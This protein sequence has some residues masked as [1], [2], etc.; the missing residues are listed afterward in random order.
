MSNLDELRRMPYQDRSPAFL[1]SSDDVLNGYAPFDRTKFLSEGRIVI[2]GL[3]RSGNHWLTNLIADSLHLTFAENVTFTHMPLT[4]SQTEDKTLIRAV[5]L[6]RDIRDVIVSLYHFMHY[7]PVWQRAPLIHYYN[8]EQYY[9]DIFVRCY[10]YWPQF[11]EA[12]TQHILSASLGTMPVVHYERLWDDTE[13]E[14]KWLFDWWNIDVSEDNIKNSIETNTIETYRNKHKE[15]LTD[16]V[17][18]HFS[19]GGGYGKWKTELPE[20]VIKDIHRR[21]GDYLRDYG[22]EVD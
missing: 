15:S 22:Y 4:T 6:L 17:Q 20:I 3:P 14:L 5:Y 21:F 9:F 19:R 16:K 8:I 1:L 18:E 2:F 11:G 7:P 12:W 13:R 10:Q